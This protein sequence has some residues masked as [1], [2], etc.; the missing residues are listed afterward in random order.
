MNLQQWYRSAREAVDDVIEH[1]FEDLPPEGHR[2]LARIWQYL[3]DQEVRAIQH[4]M[5]AKATLASELRFSSPS[6][7]TRLSTAD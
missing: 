1:N 7:A 2:R 5:R 6:S 3:R 4:D